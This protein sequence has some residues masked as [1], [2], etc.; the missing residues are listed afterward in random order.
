M[1]E[2][3]NTFFNNINSDN[4]SSISQRQSELQEARTLELYELALCLVASIKELKWE[5]MNI[6][7]ILT[8]V[9]EY[10]IFPES[11]IHNS[12]LDA[13]KQRLSHYFSLLSL[14][15]RLN[16]VD[17]L[18]DVLA[19][20]DMVVSEKDFLQGNDDLQTFIYLK[21]SL[22]DEAYDVFSV[23]FRDP[24]LR[25]ATSLNDVARAV[26]DG[27]ATYGLLPL[28]EGGERLHLAS[29]LIYRYDLKINQVTPVFGLDGL[30]DMK[31]ALISRRFNVPVI[32]PGDDSYLEIRVDDDSPLSDILVMADYLGCSV[33]RIK[34]ESFSI[35]GERENCYS[36]VLKREEGSFVKILCFLTMFIQSCVFVGI[37]KNL[38]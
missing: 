1:P 11:V 27:E 21:N 33:Y 29:K 8:Y 19:N 35:D 5:G 24:R 22:S 9:S 3:F 12:A 14:T 31:Y 28:E 30:A 6:T 7:E 32:E 23:N 34:S 38:E 4:I 20:E 2:G 26:F 13:N 10:L 15:D 36:L 25:Y 16:F 37:Y 18:V 17:Y